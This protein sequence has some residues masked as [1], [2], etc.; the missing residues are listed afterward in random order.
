MKG[1]ATM[2]CGSR[3]L[4]RR[5]IPGVISGGTCH[6]SQVRRYTCHPELFSEKWAPISTAFFTESSEWF[7]NA[8]LVVGTRRHKND[9]V[10]PFEE[11]SGIIQT[12]SRFP[13][14][15]SMTTP[16]RGR[17]LGRAGKN[18]CKCCEYSHTLHAP[19]C[20][21]Q[22]L[23]QSTLQCCSFRCAVRTPSLRISS[24]PLPMWI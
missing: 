20:R 22:A 17:V 2:Q 24:A 19:Y 11:L 7:H 5:T 3:I 23:H 16:S 18:F 15:F 13:S 14:S 6:A 9:S 4:L 12:P 1:V 8:R 21:H 10:H